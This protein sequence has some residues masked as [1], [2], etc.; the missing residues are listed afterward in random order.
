MFKKY[1]V[2]GVAML[3]GGTV[4]MGYIIFGGEKG[5]SRKR[6]PAWEARQGR[7]RK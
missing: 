4:F 6:T 1:P 7:R 3:I 5:G 2:L